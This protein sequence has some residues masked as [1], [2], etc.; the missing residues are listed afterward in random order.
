MGGA[1]HKA[2][3]GNII[4]HASCTR[5]AFRKGKGESR[6]AKVIDSPCLPEGDA[7][8]AITQNG[9]DDWND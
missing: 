4:A 1:A 3:G 6:I 8:F 2:I 9:I 7:V 5:L